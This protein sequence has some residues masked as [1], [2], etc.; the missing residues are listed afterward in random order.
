[1]IADE[2]SG[3]I[4]IVC[5]HVFAIAGLTFVQARTFAQVQEQ[6]LP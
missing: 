4:L 5:W 3:S 1:V 6:I 2:G